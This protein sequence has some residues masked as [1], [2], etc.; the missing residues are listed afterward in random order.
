MKSE[1]EHTLT[2][3][4]ICQLILIIRLIIDVTMVWTDISLIGFLSE[5][6]GNFCYNLD[7]YLLPFEP[8]FYN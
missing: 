8:V 3:T 7:D 4:D 5:P 2:S 1:P 6:F